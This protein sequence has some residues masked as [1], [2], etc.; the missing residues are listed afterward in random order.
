MTNWFIDNKDKVASILSNKKGV[1]NK[2]ALGICIFFG[3]MLSTTI[4]SEKIHDVLGMIT[5]IVL[6]IISIGLF[7]IINKLE[8][9]VWNYEFIKEYNAIISSCLNNIQDYIKNNLDDDSLIADPIY[10]IDTQINQEQFINKVKD[11]KKGSITYYRLKKYLSSTNTQWLINSK[12]ST[13]I[14]CVSPLRMTA[15]CL[16]EH[17]VVFISVNIS[18]PKCDISSVKILEEKY[19]QLDYSISNDKVVIGEF[20][21]SPI[22][23]GVVD[24]LSVIFNVLK[25]FIK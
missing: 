23:N 19:Y 21:A 10:I 6:M 24:K 13:E 25:P 15:V 2:V 11:P 1:L 22:N 12:T 7:F 3:L 4:I 18:L 16:L 9:K 14:H 5:F 17:S 20:S 8:N